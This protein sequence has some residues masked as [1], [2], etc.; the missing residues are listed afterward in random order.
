MRLRC[1]QDHLDS[2]DV[3]CTGTLGTLTNRERDFLS[4]AQLIVC[5]AFDGGHMEKQ[6]V[7]A[8]VIDKSKAPAVESFNSSFFQFSSHSLKYGGGR[9]AGTN[10]LVTT[11]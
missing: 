3:L 4:F 1:L 5:T 10:T 9:H 11:A 7:A 8:A 2:A 6:V